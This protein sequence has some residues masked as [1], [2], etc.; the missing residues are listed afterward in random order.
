MTLREW[1]DLAAPLGL[2]G[3]EFY[4]GFLELKDRQMWGESRRLVNR[5]MKEK[6]GVR[7]R[8][9]TVGDGVPLQRAIA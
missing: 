3:L 8:Y 7:L 6:L 4:S 2:D 9:P 1:V 5:K